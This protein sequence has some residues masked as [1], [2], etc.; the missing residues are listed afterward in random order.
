MSTLVKTR[1]VKMGRS[2]GVRIPKRWLDRLGLRAE[3]E[4]AVQPDQIV[5]RPSHHPRKGWDEQFRA[6]AQRGDDKL[7]NGAVQTN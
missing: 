4:V 3:V 2:R 7:L 5:I 1:I 6:M